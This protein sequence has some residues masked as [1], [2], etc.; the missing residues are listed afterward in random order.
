[1]ARIAWVLPA[2]AVQLLW[3]LLG[4]LCDQHGL[5]QRP[6][7]TPSSGLHHRSQEALWVE[8]ACISTLSAV[9]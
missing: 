9:R 5:V 2:G 8:Q 7:I 4:D 6:V 1:M 3:Q